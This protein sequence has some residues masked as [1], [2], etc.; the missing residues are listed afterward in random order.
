[1]EEPDRAVAHLGDQLQDVVPPQVPP[2]ERLDRPRRAEDLVVQLDDQ[3]QL[4]QTDHVDGG[5]GHRCP[6]PEPPAG[7]VRSL[8]DRTT[9]HRSG[10][11]SP[12]TISSH[13]GTFQLAITSRA[14][15][16]VGSSNPAG[17]SAAAASSAS[18]SSSPAASSSS[19]ASAAGAA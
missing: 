1:E 4:V 17:D 9:G 2:A 7:V 18:S 15:S 10:R 12:A 3:R 13:D 19:P 14:A 11:Y 16:A 6:L 5:V 8:R